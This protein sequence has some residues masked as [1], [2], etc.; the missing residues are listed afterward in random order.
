MNISKIISVLF[1]LAGVTYLVL[2][3]QLEPASIGNPNAPKIF[4]GMVAVLMI[5][6]S[7]ALLA[8]EL[9]ATTTAGETGQSA[10]FDLEN[11]VKIILVC[12]CAAIYALLFNRLGYVLSTTIFLEGVLTVF[13]GLKRWKQNTLVAVIFS[14]VVYVLFFKLLNVY[15][16]S[17]PFF[18]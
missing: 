12:V 16:P 3:F 1:L 5:G 6:L 10:G 2:V 18:E 4:P 15:L 8:Q 7:I 11:V 13:N 17:F 14:I 9:L